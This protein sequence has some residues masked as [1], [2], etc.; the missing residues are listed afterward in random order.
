MCD[1]RIEAWE[2]AV[3]SLEDQRKAIVEKLN[4]MRQVT[5]N[6]GTQLQALYKGRRADVAA[7][8]AEAK[9][10]PRVQVQEPHETADPAPG[11]L[12]RKLDNAHPASQH[13]VIRGILKKRKTELNKP[14]VGTDRA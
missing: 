11:S 14:E 3:M 5:L 7:L 1:A 9:K 4:D 2:A 12:K 8:C 13:Q 10:K 6:H